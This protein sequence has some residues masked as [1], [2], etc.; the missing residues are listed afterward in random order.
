M[1]T[2][3]ERDLKGALDA[4]T[5][6]ALQLEQRA[7]EYNR[8]KRNFD[9][10]AKLS[11]QVGGRDLETSVA[12]HLKTN[13]VRVLDV[14]RCRSPVSPN[15]TRDARIALV[16]ALVLGIG[17]AMLLELARLDGARR[18]KTSRRSAG[19]VFLGLIPSIGVEHAQTAT[20]PPARLPTGP[21]RARP[22]RSRRSR[23]R[24]A[25]FAPIS[26]S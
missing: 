9:R 18:R 19:L 15:V 17:L 3:Q 23:N 4:A 11:E 13:N 22:S 26:C 12:G 1:L 8:L 2:R 6:E 25:R 5:H 10:L 16:A 14:A 20:A 21:V 24:A 7:I